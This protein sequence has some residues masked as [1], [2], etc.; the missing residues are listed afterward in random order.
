M[1]LT[2]HRI[3]VDRRE[4][5]RGV[6]AVVGGPHHDRVLGDAQLV[7]LVEDHAGEVVH[8]G[9]DVGPVPPL[10]L[11]RVL[12][13]RDRRDVDLRVGQVDVEGLACLLGAGHEIARPLGDL[14]VEPGP[15][16]GV[17][18]RDDLGLLALLPRVDRLR[19][20]RD[21]RLPR[22]RGGG[23][24]AIREV[25][26]HRP[27]HLIGGARAPHRLVEPEVHRAALLGVAAQVPLA[28]HPGGVPGVRQCLGD[29]DLPP[30]HPVRPAGDDPRFG[31]PS[32]SR[33]ARSA[34][35]TGSACTAPRR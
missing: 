18:D 6:G 1:P 8:L 3:R 29:R 30:G 16:L 12:R 2:A 10:G 31:C 27:Q 23:H 33:G 20:Q 5:V 14:P 19:F 35:P 17:V 24:R 34:T 22:I 13:V 32:G 9:E 15:E 7:E 4:A 11:A 25:G 21:L 26:L 28:P